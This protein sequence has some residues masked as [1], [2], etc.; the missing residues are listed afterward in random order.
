MTAIFTERHRMPKY[1]KY[2]EGAMT[3]PNYWTEAEKAIIKRYVFGEP[4]GKR[5]W[6]NTDDRY[7]YLIEFKVVDHWDRNL[8]SLS[9]RSACGHK[10]F[11]VIGDLPLED[12]AA[13]K[14]HCHKCEAMWR[15]HEAR[16]P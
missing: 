14:G 6:R 5:G 2:E 16:K 3:D 7:H 10:T 9:Y 8:V 4:T 13:W 15:E 11:S 1:P 12:Y